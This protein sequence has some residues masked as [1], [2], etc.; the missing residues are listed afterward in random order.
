MIRVVDETPKLVPCKQLP[1]NALCRLPSG[2]IALRV[3]ESMLRSF[4]PVWLV[5]ISEVNSWS[6]NGELLVEPI[7]GELVI[8]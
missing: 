5:G 6:G 8:D 2:A 3:D 7:T 1:R 4:G